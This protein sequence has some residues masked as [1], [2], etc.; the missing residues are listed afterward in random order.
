VSGTVWGT[1]LYTADSNICLAAIHAGVIKPTGGPFVLIKT[2]GQPQ[3]KGTIANMVATNNL[4]RPYPIS[5]SLAI[6]NSGW[7]AMMNYSKMGNGSIYLEKSSTIFL[8][9]SSHLLSKMLHKNPFLFSSFIQTKLTNN[10][11]PEP[12]WEW[13]ESDPKHKFSNTGAITISDKPLSPMD[14]YTIIL[15]FNLSEFKGRT[16]LFSCNENPGYNIFINPDDNLVVGSMSGND[17]ID[18]QLK[19]PLNRMVVI[20][21][22]H[23]NEKLTIAIIGTD[24]KPV[25][26]KKKR[27]IQSCSKIGIGRHATNDQDYFFG[28]LNF[29]QFYNKAIDLQMVPII[30]DATHKK[31]KSSVKLNKS[32]T[33]DNRACITACTNAPIPGTP[34]APKMPPEADPYPPDIHSLSVEEKSKKKCDG[35][36]DD[37][38]DISGIPGG[39]HI[40]VDLVAKLVEQSEIIAQQNN[41]INVNIQNTIGIRNDIN[42]VPG[43]PGA[44]NPN[45]PVPTNNGG[46]STNMTINHN[47]K[48]TNLTCEITLRDKRFDG[49]IG[50]K[51]RVRCDEDCSKRKDINVFGSYIYGPDSSVCKAAYHSG[52]LEKGSVGY[53]VVE[54]VEGKKIYNQSIGSDGSLSVTSGPE[55]RSFLTRQATPPIKISCT[56][57]ANTSEFASANVGKKFLVLCPPGCSKV[58][59]VI[60]Y[61]EEIYPDMSPICLSAIHW[62]LITDQGGEFEFMIEGSQ[63][64]YKGTKGFGIDSTARGQYIRSFRLVGVRSTIFTQYKEDFQGKFLEKYIVF[65]DPTLYTVPT[66][67]WAFEKINSVVINNDKT[68]MAISNK[69]KIISNNNYGTM[70]LLKNIEFVNGRFRASWMFSQNLTHAILFRYQDPINFYAV[71]FNLENRIGSNIRLVKRVDNSFKTVSQARRK[72]F[73]KKWYKISILMNFDQISVYLQ[74]DNLRMNELLFDTKMGDIYR[75]TVGFGA[76]GSTDFYISG[77]EIDNHL[78]KDRIKNSLRNRRTSTKI[79]Q[80]ASEKD[81]K[82]YCTKEFMPNDPNLKYCLMPRVYCKIRCDDHIPPIE[83]ILNY[84]CMKDCLKTVK[85][86]DG[87]TKEVEAKSQKPKEEDKE[88]PGPKPGLK[89][90]FLPPF[91]KSNQD[92]TPGTVKNVKEIGGKWFVDIEYENGFN[93]LQIDNNLEY[94]GDGKRLKKCKSVLTRR[95]DCDDPKDKNQDIA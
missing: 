64:A 43:V 85:E 35:S 37:V 83:N 80:Q 91:G 47:V 81:R 50:Q 90:D 82:A 31:P 4:N 94:P 79:L 51:F 78:T 23:E 84:N 3:Y 92:Y 61:G 70:I 15:Q 59:N 53:I 41:I 14:T 52:V 25:V 16:F 28:I 10:S 5:F 44:P 77:I 13:L 58:K 46:G 62:G 63:T 27:Q 33:V 7:R 22:T 39:E 87:K 36:S 40:N 48:I 93:N 2:W 60:V 88:L 95:T 66:E 11:L 75:G 56:Q 68:L 67:G 12:V 65:P 73:I 54:L 30:V 49:G 26:I 76:N 72:I 89:L 71:E 45:V 17:S 24:V 57:G 55:L 32:T 8:K 74:S 38:I 19:I 9:E 29:I 69:T 42:V 6:V 34:G 18:T 21:I 1:G 20:S 86:E